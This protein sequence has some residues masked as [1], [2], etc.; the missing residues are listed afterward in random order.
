VEVAYGRSLPE[1][2][3]ADFPIRGYEF[4]DYRVDVMN[5]RF[6]NYQDNAVRKTGALSWLLFTGAGVTTESTVSGAK[7]INAKP[8]YFPKIDERFDND[9]RGGSAY[10]TAAIH[11]LDGSVTGIPNSYVLINDSANDSVA[12]DRTCKL[13][14]TWNAAVCTGDV[15]RLSFRAGQLA[16]LS[17]GAGKGRG[18]FNFGY[19]RPTFLP[20]GA[21]RPAPPPPEK[22]IELVRNGKEFH[23]TADQS[24]VRAGSEI[25]VKTERPKVTL[26]LAEMDQGSWVI[27]DLPGFATAAS[28]TEQA[29]LDALRKASETS[30]FKDGANLWVKLVVAK[31]LIKPVRPSNI[32]ASVAVSRGQAVAAGTASGAGANAAGKS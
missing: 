14:P 17:Q 26:S 32:Q 19:V 12:T 21:P 30:Y 16:A 11:D 2:K 1:P 31:P 7:Y 20:A 28:G 15:G 22:P 25:E 4:Y 9:N 27:F 24:T 13:Q 29:S 10:R 23:I 5:T 3:V 8:V 18:G 6:V